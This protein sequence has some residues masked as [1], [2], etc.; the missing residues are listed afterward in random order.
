MCEDWLNR[1]EIIEFRSLTYLRSLITGCQCFHDQETYDSMFLIH[2]VLTKWENYK[3][4]RWRANFLIWQRDTTV[5][6][7][8]FCVSWEQL[9]QI[10]KVDLDRR[11]NGFDLKFRGDF[12]VLVFSDSHNLDG[13]SST[14]DLHKKIIVSVPVWMSVEITHL[15]QAPTP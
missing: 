2:K 1:R 14:D 7:D 15:R 9:S 6:L 8:I 13:F 3:Y 4:L 11:K 5:R 10:V 12:Y